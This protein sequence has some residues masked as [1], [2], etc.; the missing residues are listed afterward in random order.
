MPSAL[1]EFI[2]VD[3]AAVDMG[4]TVHL[5][6]LVLPA[7]VEFWL[8]SMVRSTI[9]RLR[10]LLNPERLKRCGLILLFMAE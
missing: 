5:S 3:L 10:K 4:E 2:E 8:C 7:G 1:P 6:D 9:I